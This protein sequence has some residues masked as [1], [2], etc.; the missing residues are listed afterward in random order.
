[1]AMLSSRSV[2]TRV[3]SVVRA[4]YGR[5]DLGIC[6]LMCER[7][8]MIINFYGRSRSGIF[9]DVKREVNEMWWGWL[10]N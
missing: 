1:M 8:C 2:N 4:A 7:S 5:Q 6:L 10:L 9:S 3:A